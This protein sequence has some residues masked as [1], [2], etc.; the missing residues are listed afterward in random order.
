[1]RLLPLLIALP[2]LA[3]AQAPDPRAIFAP[4]PMS[5]PAGLTRSAGG[6]P[7][8]AYWQNRADYGIDAHIDA[9]PHVLRA[10]ET[11]TYTNNSPD[12]L[13]V[14]WLQLDQNIYR[15]DSRAAFMPQYEERHKG[16]YTEGDQIESIRIDAGGQTYT[17]RSIV[18]DTRLQIHLASA[19]THGGHLRIVIGYHYTIPGT[20]GG[21]HRGHAEQERRDF[22]DRAMV[23]AH[24]GLRRF[25]RLEHHPLPRFG[26]LLRVWRHRL[27]CDGADRFHCCRLGRID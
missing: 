17:P 27:C 10:T 21:P 14:L 2:A 13:D 3:H 22:R 4:F 25:A 18:T 7:G 15:R 6:V 24:G 8:P 5:E 23:P 16:Q 12:A 19:L 20:W 11:I 26:I 9:P 1:M